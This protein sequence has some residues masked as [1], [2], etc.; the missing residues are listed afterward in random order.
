MFAK[1]GQAASLSEAHDQAQE[2]QE[3]PVR[4]PVADPVS[5]PV[6]RPSRTAPSGIAL[7]YYY[8]CNAVARLGHDARAQA[9]FAP[10]GQM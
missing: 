8:S 5:D 10:V 2:A 1:C 9:C 6:D 4:V 3:V 7:R